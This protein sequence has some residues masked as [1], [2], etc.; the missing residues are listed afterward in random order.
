MAITSYAKV[1]LYRLVP[2]S[3]PS[4]HY[5]WSYGCLNTRKKEIKIL[6]K[7]SLTTSVSVLYWLT[8]YKMQVYH[9]DEFHIYFLREARKTIVREF[10]EV[11]WWHSFPV[12]TKFLIRIGCLNDLKRHCLCLYLLYKI[13]SNFCFVLFTS[14]LQNI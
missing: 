8:V 1:I 2:I 9:R 11:R 7:L 6:N 10:I 12:N 4:D 13:F 5:F 3:T 14:P